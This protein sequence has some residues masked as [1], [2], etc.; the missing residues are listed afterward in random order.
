MAAN[1]VWNRRNVRVVVQ[2]A[3]SLLVTGAGARWRTREP[4]CAGRASNG[5]AD[6]QVL[7]FFPRSSPS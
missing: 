7:S 3:A 5:K 2:E 4:G 1:P 6:G